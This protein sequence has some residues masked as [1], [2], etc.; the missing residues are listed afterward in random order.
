MT[1]HEAQELL[2]LSHV[3][4]K[5]RGYLKAFSDELDALAC[6]LGHRAPARVAADMRDISN[7]MEVVA[8]G[9][10]SFVNGWIQQRAEDEARRQEVQ[11]LKRRGQW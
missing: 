5:L 4:R 2:R 6:S 1:D 11:V 8:G 7:Q 10:T 9:S 3:E